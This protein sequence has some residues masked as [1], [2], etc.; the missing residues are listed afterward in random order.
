[1]INHIV[2]DVADVSV[3]LRCKCRASVAVSP[4]DL[5]LDVFQC[6]NCGE[7]WPKSVSKNRRPESPEQRLAVALQEIANGA[8]SAGYQMQFEVTVP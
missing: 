4:A 1:M 3:R 6:P 7:P 8:L 5:S 2:V